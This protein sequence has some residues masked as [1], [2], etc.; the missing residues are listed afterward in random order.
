MRKSLSSL[1]TKERS[2]A[3]RSRCTLL[4]KRVTWVNRWWFAFSLSK[5]ERFARKN[6]IRSF[7]HVFSLLYP[8]LCPRANRSRRSSLRRS[9]QKSDR[10][11]ERFAPLAIKKEQNR[12]SLFGKQRITISLF[13]SQ[14]TSNFLEK[15]KSEFPTLIKYENVCLLSMLQLFFNSIFMFFATLE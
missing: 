3:N 5:N 13:R 12:D 9:L 8:Y 11:R 10:E 6:S 14:K 2:W 1:F 15:P 7:H 4:W